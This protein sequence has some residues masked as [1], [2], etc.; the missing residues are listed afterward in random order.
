NASYCRAAFE[1][2]IQ[3][4]Q[5][6]TATEKLNDLRAFAAADIQQ[7]HIRHA[8]TVPALHK[9][10]RTDQNVDLGV[11][12]LDTF[13][14]RVADFV[15]LQLDLWISFF[16]ERFEACRITNINQPEILCR[17]ANLEP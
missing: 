16:N 1:A 8:P 15:L 13:K 3:P 11:Y 14:E 5:P 12:P 7:T 6:N 4:F 10:F 17:T 2:A 9:L